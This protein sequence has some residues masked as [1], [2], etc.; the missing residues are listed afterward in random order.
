MNTLSHTPAEVVAALMIG[1]THNYSGENR[2]LF[3]TKAGISIFDT[4]EALS[5]TKPQPYARPDFTS[6]GELHQMVFMG[7]GTL[8]MKTWCDAKYPDKYYVY[9]LAKKAG[10]IYQ[11]AEDADADLTRFSEDAAW[12]AEVLNLVFAEY[13][14]DRAKYVAVAA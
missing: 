14:A 3:Q 8:K 1:G 9:A 4:A 12:H 6:P 2:P 11:P 13:E 7:L 10:W 5:A